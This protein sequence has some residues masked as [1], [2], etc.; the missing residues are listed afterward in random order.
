MSRY[1]SR[2]A[3]LPPAL[4]LGR[5]SE[6]YWFNGMGRR[7][8]PTAPAHLLGCDY[9]RLWAFSPTPPRRLTD[10]LTIALPTTRRATPPT[11]S[12]VGNTISRSSSTRSSASIMVA[13]PKMI[14]EAGVPIMWTPSSTWPV[15]VHDHLHQPAR[16]GGMG[17]GAGR[18]V[19]GEESARWRPA[20]GA[21]PARC[22]PTRARLPRTGPRR[23]SPARY[24]PPTA[25]RGSASGCRRAASTRWHPP[26][27]R[28]CARRRAPAGSAR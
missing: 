9:H 8:Q 6:R 14:S 7:L 13:A 19:L 23:R 11:R 2:R 22:V 5:G 20:A 26:P 25:P 10:R 16:R 28:P 4:A 21:P 17:A 3:A 15:G 12:D 24:T 27:P 1:T 18:Q